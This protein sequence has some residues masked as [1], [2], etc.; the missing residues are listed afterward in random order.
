[1]LVLAFDGIVRR[2]R[3]MNCVLTIVLRAIYNYWGACRVLA[4]VL[5]KCSGCRVGSWEI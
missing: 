2:G 3:W 1:V 5:L 4:M